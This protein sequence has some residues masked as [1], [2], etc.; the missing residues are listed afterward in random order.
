MVGGGLNFVIAAQGG[1][2]DCG[3]SLLNQLCVVLYT[4]SESLRRQLSLY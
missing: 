2:S 1:V 4:I 3:R